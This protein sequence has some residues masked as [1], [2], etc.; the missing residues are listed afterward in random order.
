MEGAIGVARQ[1]GMSDQLIGLTIVA[2]GTSLPELAT[3]AIAA[4]RGHG[5]IAVGNLLVE[6]GRLSAVI[7]F[8]TSGVGDPA[9]DLVIAWTFFTGAARDRFRAEVAQDDGRWARAR[10]WALWKALISL[11]GSAEQDAVNLRVIADVLAEA[12]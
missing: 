1:A 6:H 7:D 10:G 4:V 11:T 2:V 9:C 5:D 8:G 12:G 3:S